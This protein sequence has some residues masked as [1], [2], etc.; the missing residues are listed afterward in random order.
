M[1]SCVR[2]SDAP[3]FLASVYMR[4]MT[5]T[6]SSPPY[7]DVRG[8][9]VSFGKEAEQMMPVAVNS[10]PKTVDCVTRARHSSAKISADHRNFILFVSVL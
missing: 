3:P 9:I 7:T 8:T 5:A 2:S 4:C 1:F 6:Y 10:R